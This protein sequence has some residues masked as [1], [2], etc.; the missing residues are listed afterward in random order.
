MRNS[1]FKTTA[2]TL[3]TIS[4]VS[5]SL[6]PCAYAETIT[7][8]V[9]VNSGEERVIASDINTG[10]DS[11]TTALR[12]NG[13]AA[14]VKGNVT[15]KGNAV[16]AEQGAAVN[17]SGDVWSDSWAIY[18][19]D[20][21]TEVS[22]GGDVSGRNPAVFATAGSEVKVEGNIT[23]S[24]RY[25]VEAYQI[26]TS[27]DV[28]GDVSGGVMAGKGAEV[29]VK[30]D[31][32]GSAGVFSYDG[33][34]AS[35]NGNVYG[36]TGVDAF[37]GGV[38]NVGGDIIVGHPK[39]E[40]FDPTNNPSYGIQTDG[41]S[42][43]TVNGDIS[44]SYAA[45]H[46]IHVVVDGQDLDY[47]PGTIVVD[48]SINTSSYG[49]GY[50]GTSDKIRV[51]TIIVYSIESS[52]PV[53]VLDG[54]GFDRDTVEEKLTDNIYYIIRKGD[55][56]SEFS[57]SGHTEKEGYDT[58]IE[59]TAVIINVS[60]GYELSS[61]GKA[62]LKK[63]QDGTYTLTVPR[64]GNVTISALKAAIKEAEEE[65]GKEVAVPTESD[66]DED[67]SGSTTVPSTPDTPFNGVIDGSSMPEDSYTEQIAN[68]IANV[69]Q[70]GSLILNITNGF[71]LN[72][73]LI[74]ALRGR[75]DVSS[76]LVIRFFGIPFWIRIPAGYDLDRLRGRNGR[77]T[78]DSLFRAF[79][80]VPGF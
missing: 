77:V 26:G 52:T 35:I 36:Q 32:S 34:S 13:G 21:G 53:T 46:G 18:A 78:Y 27:V 64:G 56:A 59:G 58:A 68:Q 24:N 44:S 5:S 6:S 55:N 23:S 31:V 12:V 9:T 76:Y 60:E 10:T 4:L 39:T 80:A 63:N 37:T 61:T 71:Y 65:T 17:V 25:G 7:E 49:I 54:G 72:D 43:I 29:T 73:T 50:T 22:V 69:P 70:G 41:T 1:V 75:R 47:E 28:G 11:R 48:G 20:A 19:A 30:G 3:L 57:Y 15:G 62:T 42:N 2:V 67:S 51:P 16:W 8:G 38:V 40:D 74:S 45:S 79:G 33:G 14:E 66:D